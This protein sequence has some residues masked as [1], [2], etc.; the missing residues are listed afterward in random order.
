MRIR[1]EGSGVSA[2][3]QAIV[4]VITFLIKSERKGVTV[5]MLGL[6]HTGLDSNLTPIK[7]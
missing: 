3:K 1:R 7:E 4:L 6:G 5:E 2:V